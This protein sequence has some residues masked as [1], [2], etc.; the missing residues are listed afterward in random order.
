MLVP[1]VLCLTY[2]FTRPI[3]TC[4]NITKKQYLESDNQ[5]IPH[6]LTNFRNKLVIT[7][8][9]SRNHSKY[10]LINESHETYNSL[11]KIKLQSTSISST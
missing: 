11:K 2:V 7:T 1:W 9:Y 10:M 4:I 8:K 5:V 3:C 6:S